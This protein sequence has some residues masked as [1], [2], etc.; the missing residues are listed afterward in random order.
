MW[1]AL[2]VGDATIFDSTGLHKAAHLRDDLPLFPSVRDLMQATEAQHRTL[3]SVVADE[4]DLEAVVRATE[5]VVGPLDKPE[6]GL[7]FALP[8]IKAW[9]LRPPG[10]G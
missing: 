5:A 2:G 6:A 10:S 7:M 4:M 9:G 8:I 1:T 3:W